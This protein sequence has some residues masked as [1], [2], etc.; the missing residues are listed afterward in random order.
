MCDKQCRGESTKDDLL[1]RSVRKEQEILN[2]EL[3]NHLKQI[4]KIGADG[5]KFKINL[6]IREKG[7]LNPDLGPRPKKEKDGQNLEISSK[8]YKLGSL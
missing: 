1:E 7:K 3:L 8:A 2:T 4:S 5:R 6:G